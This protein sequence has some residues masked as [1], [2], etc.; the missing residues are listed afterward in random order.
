MS[1]DKRQPPILNRVTI[2]YAVSV[3]LLLK[4]DVQTVYTAISIITCHVILYEPCTKGTNSN[5]FT[6]FGYMKNDNVP[7]QPEKETALTADFY[8]YYIM[9]NKP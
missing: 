5:I 9:N 3:C 2:S 8:I 7:C 4:Q 1:S 6:Y